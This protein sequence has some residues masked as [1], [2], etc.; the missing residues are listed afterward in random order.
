VDRHA[1]WYESDASG[2]PRAE[3][4]TYNL[5]HALVTLDGRWS[6]ILDD[7]GFSTALKES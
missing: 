3:T 7:A 6:S 5:D 4:F 2:A 1:G